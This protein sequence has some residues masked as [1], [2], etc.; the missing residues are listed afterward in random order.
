MWLSPMQ[1]FDYTVDSDEE[2]EEEEPGESISHSEVCT[3][4]IS[5]IL[6]STYCCASLATL[7]LVYC[8]ARFTTFPLAYCCASLTAL[9]VL[10]C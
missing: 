3:T 8:C 1:V 10:L 7:S 5:Y 6:R 9:S 2:W 4:I